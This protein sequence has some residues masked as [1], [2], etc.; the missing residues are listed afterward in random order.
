MRSPFK[1]VY[2][3]GEVVLPSRTRDTFTKKGVTPPT[4][5][6]ARSVLELEVKM[7]FARIAAIAAD[8]KRRPSRDQATRFHANTPRLQVP[9]DGKEI[10][11]VPDDDKVPRCNVRILRP[12][13][14][15]RHA[16]DSSHDRAIGNGQN[17]SP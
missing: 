3:L 2:S 10:I 8:A 11:P 4:R 16:V 5:L 17:L 9:V 13:D 7:R 6:D 1:N 14:V 15:F 12:G